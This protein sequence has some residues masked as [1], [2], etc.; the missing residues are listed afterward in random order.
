MRSFNKTFAVDLQWWENIHFCSL[1][2]K[3]Q[4]R[5][6]T[7]F[8]LCPHFGTRKQSWHLK[9][10][11]SQKLW[12]I[13]WRHLFDSLRRDFWLRNKLIVF[14]WEKRFCKSGT[15][16]TTLKKHLWVQVQKQLKVRSSK[17]SHTEAHT[18]TEHMS[19]THTYRD[20]QTH[21]Q[22]PTPTHA[23]T[24]RERERDTHTRANTKQI[25]LHICMNPQ[26]GLNP[27]CRRAG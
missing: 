8:C 2:V 23:H 18:D 4:M 12:M 20:R 26:L 3:Q 13:A 6:S 27:Q 15:N 5:T 21:T 11:H 24:Q 19:Q 9:L 22:R 1:G 14:C 10:S 17:V 7:S 25:N 16:S